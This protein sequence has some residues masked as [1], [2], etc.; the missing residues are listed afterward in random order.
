[1]VDLTDIY[2]YYNPCKQNRKPP[3]ISNVLWRL[4]RVNFL[5]FSSIN[6][7]KAFNAFYLSFG[8]AAGG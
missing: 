4:R 6:N 8:N 7:N 2:C 3:L 5:N 1:M